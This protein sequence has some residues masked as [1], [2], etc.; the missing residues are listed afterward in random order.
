MKI[1]ITSQLQTYKPEGSPPLPVDE[2]KES[3]LFGGGGGIMA[4][5]DD[6]SEASVDLNGYTIIMKKWYY[7]IALLNWP[8]AQRTR[9]HRN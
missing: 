6:I 3:G 1:L 4:G 2:T 7:K 9:R 5:S 8:K